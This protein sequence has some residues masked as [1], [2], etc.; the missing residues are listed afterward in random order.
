M[1]KNKTTVSKLWANS[2]YL[3]KW[4]V[5]Y[6]RIK[7]LHWFFASTPLWSGERKRNGR[8]C[9]ILS[10]CYVTK[11]YTASFQAALRLLR[12]CVI[13]YLRMNITFV[14][15]LTKH[16]RILLN[17]WCQSCRAFS[18]VAMVSETENCSWSCQGA[19][20]P[21]RSREIGHLSRF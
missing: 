13:S 21:S 5:N 4:T 17:I 11:E 3:N 8:S 14:H 7:L 16:E 20:F 19:C 2:G 15:V 18:I 10:A 1:E 9:R 6:V 12:T